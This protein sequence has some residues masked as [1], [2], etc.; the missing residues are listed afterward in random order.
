MKS[1][2]QLNI[3]FIIV[4]TIIYII[5]CYNTNYRSIH[6]NNNK[7]SEHDYRMIYFTTVYGFIYGTVLVSFQQRYIEKNIDSIWVWIILLFICVLLVLSAF[8]S[9]VYTEEDTNSFLGKFSYAMVPILPSLV[10][11]SE[12][13]IT[14]IIIHENDYDSN[15]SD[16]SNTSSNSN[17][18]QESVDSFDK[19]L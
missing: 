5:L 10:M 18:S 9:Q 14:Q 8:Y 1:I 17:T 19:L 2:D 3:G 13:S 11:L 12:S 15:Y 6:Y 16:T 7:L 4:A